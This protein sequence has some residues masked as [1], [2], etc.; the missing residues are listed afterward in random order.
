MKKANFILIAVIFLFQA[1]A[2]T[3][4][5]AKIVK[6]TD[7]KKL[8][9]FR[10]ISYM[11]IIEKGNKAALSKSLSQESTEILDS[12]II[13]K[14]EAFK[15]TNLLT[16]SD[17]IINKKLNS[18]ISKLTYEAS[19]KVRVHNL[20]LSPTIDSIMEANQERFAIA[21]VCT[22]FSRVKGNY[23]GQVAKGIGV[24]L[25]TLGMYTPVPVKANSNI[26]AV[27]FD[28]KNNTVALYK[29]SH[30]SDKEPT[31]RSTVNK[32]INYVMINLLKSQSRLVP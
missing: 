2:P 17:S 22:G 4:E 10:P 27:I 14:K 32:Q 5:V 24:G 23:G 21:F 12:L 1:C 3:E 30:V 6:P 29:G 8:G 16:P 31:N 13:S 20:N 11:G 7:I 19:T 9:Y 28:S 26:H 18:E 15:V 25:L